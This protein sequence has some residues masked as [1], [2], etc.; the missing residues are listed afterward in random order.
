MSAPRVLLWVQHLLGIGHLKRAATLARALA[1]EGLEV[2]L[3]SGGMPVP[4]LARQ[5]GA[6]G[7]RVV[8]LPPARAADLGFRD[9]LDENGRAV[10]ADWRARRT[11]ALLAAW[12]AADPQVLLLELFPFGRRQMRFELLPLLDAAAAASRR[13]AILC[14]VR[15]ILGGQRS[16]ERHA[17][18][19]D[20]VQ[21]FFDDVLVHGD[22]AVIAF[23][24]TFPP[25]ADLAGKLSYTGY[26]VEEPAKHAS[27]AGENE[28]I[29]SAGG[30]A[31]GE[32]LIEAAIEAKPL[33]GLRGRTWRVLAGDNLPPA[34]FSRLESLGQRVGGFAME[35]SRPDFTT[36]LANCALSISQAGY[37]TLLETVQAGA[38]AVAVPFAGGAEIEQSLRARSFA[39]RGL[40]DIVEESGLTP[41][42]LAAAADRAAARPAPAAGRIDLGGAR[43]SAALVAR[44][45]AQG[46]A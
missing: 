40:L 41:A 29:V 44:W 12:R 30:G 38:R 39:A 33:T 32:R 16:A 21:R 27:R 25:A 1:A 42:T 22:P 26:V 34:A 24:R 18:T 7:V 37:N 14:S 19:L 11:A 15:D 35:T 8:Q 36:L 31:V 23:E 43:A 3:A 20:L 2:T 28:V 17:E 45:A 9:L 10:D 5:L 13:P 6:A 46:R 4:D